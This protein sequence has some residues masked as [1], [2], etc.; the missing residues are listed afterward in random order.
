[1]P[2]ILIAEDEGHIR[3]LLEDELG[4]MGFVVDAVGNG[5]DALEKIDGQ[6]Y[7][8]LL[9][10]LLLPGLS[11]V[12]VIKLLRETRP[13]VPIVGLTD[14]L[15]HG[16]M[17]ESKRLNVTVFAKPA[18]F[19]NLVKLLKEAHEWNSGDELEEHLKIHSITEMQMAS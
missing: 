3:D 5:K 17:A 9:I 11:G 19:L 10:D 1:M 7:D 12:E 18:S 6:S 4:R 16:F 13:H 2:E 8:L 14:Y 15:G